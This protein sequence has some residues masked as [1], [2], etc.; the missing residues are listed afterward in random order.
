MNTVLRPQQC[1]VYTGYGPGTPR[2]PLHQNAGTHVG[3]P[4]CLGGMA[5]PRFSAPTPVHTTLPGTPM[6]TASMF[7]W[8][9]RQQTRLPLV[10]LSQHSEQKQLSS[11]DAQG[12]D[13]PASDSRPAAITLDPPM[14]HHLPVD[15]DETMDMGQQGYEELV[16][17]GEYDILHQAVQNFLGQFHPSG[18]NADDFLEEIGS[19]IPTDEVLKDKITWDMKSLL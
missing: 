7:F 4:R 15:I 9:E 12:S 8:Q 6:V 13:S 10:F 1:M 18:D 3:T 14:L 5:T 11:P 17:E 19:L 16:T 2:T